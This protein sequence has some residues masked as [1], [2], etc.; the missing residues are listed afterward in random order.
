MF[1]TEAYIA[2]LIFADSEQSIKDSVSRQAALGHDD[3]YFRQ[4]LESMPHYLVSSRSDSTASKYG[5]YFRRFHNFMNTHSKTAVP[6][7]SSHISLFIV[8]LLNSNVSHNVIISY[9][10]SIKWMHA[11]HGHNDP[12]NDV[13]IKCLLDSSK[14][15]PKLVNRRKDVISPE[16][17]KDLFSKYGDCPDLT[18]LRDLAMIVL[19][20]TGFLRYDELSSIKCKDLIFFDDYVSIN[21]PKSKTDQ[22]RDGNEIL[23]SKLD[24]PTCPVK[25]LSCYMTAAA[26][27]SGSEEFV[28]RA[29]YRTK[30]GTVGLRKTNKKLSYTRCKEL[31]L[32]RMREFVPDNVNLGL[33]SFRSGGATAAANSG[34]NDRCWKRHGRW[35]S[36]VAN[37]YVKD[38]VLSRME[39]S[40]NLGL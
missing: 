9:V 20:F 34:V 4:L 15:R 21:I 36:D 13:H 22:F 33:H 27:T 12:T 6:A 25:A 32:S 19:S 39:V 40:K 3:V 5:G 11:L 30:N 10:C 16:H 24:S 7:N 26:L 18:V 17:I 37:R 14:R 28:F 31:L 1:D 23:L 29:M 35:R 2:H 38:S 8:H